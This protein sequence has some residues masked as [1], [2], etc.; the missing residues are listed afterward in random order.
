[1]LK[2]TSSQARAS[3]RGRGAER[4][5]ASRVQRNPPLSLSL[6]SLRFYHRLRAAISPSA[7]ILVAPPR[8]PSVPRARG[9]D[10]FAAI[11][12][13]TG[14]PLNP[15]AIVNPRRH[16]PGIRAASDAPRKIGAYRIAPS[17]P[18]GRRQKSRRVAPKTYRR[19]PDRFADVPSRISVSCARERRVAAVE[20]F[21]NSR[22]DGRFPLTFD[23]TITITNTSNSYNRETNTPTSILI[24]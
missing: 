14:A 19:F 9:T 2:H 1:M 6:S 12:F 20:I 16:R 8:R 13:A 11:S 23:F 24:F 5:N 3:T 17:I 18:G 4:R 7:V 22:S 21:L 10:R 15:A